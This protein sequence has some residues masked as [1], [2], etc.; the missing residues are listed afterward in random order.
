LAYKDVGTSNWN[1]SLPAPWTPGQVV[2]QGG[3]LTVRRSDGVRFVV[4]LGG[5]LEDSSTRQ[6]LDLE[7]DFQAS[8]SGPTVYTVPLVPELGYSLA[9]NPSGRFTLTAFT[10]D[11]KSELLSLYALSR[12]RLFSEGEA[13]GADIALARAEGEYAGSFLSLP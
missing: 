3:Q 10:R 9:T 8:P 5:F 1:V 2:V 12:P 4:Y 11:Q 13:R 7:A 6:A